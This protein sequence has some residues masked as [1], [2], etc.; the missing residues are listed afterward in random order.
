LPKDF[1]ESIKKSART[2]DILEDIEISDIIDMV[3]GLLFFIIIPTMMGL[4]C[5][6]VKNSEVFIT[7]TDSKTKKSKKSKKKLKQKTNQNFEN[8][9]KF[10]ETLI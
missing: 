8:N 6:V 5:C 10:Y 1:I 2:A 4:C 7:W 9:Q 3:Y